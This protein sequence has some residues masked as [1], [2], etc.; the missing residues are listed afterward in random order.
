[1]M[2]NNLCEG[3]SMLQIRLYNKK[4]T[5]EEIFVKRKIN[6]FFIFQLLNGQILKGLRFSGFNWYPSSMNTHPQ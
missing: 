2:E 3:F 1:M 4:L 5:Y 6:L